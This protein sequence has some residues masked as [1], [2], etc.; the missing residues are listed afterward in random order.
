MPPEALEEEAKRSLEEQKQKEKERIEVWHM[1]HDSR[2][3]AR[4][5][6]WQPTRFDLKRWWFLRHQKTD[7]IV[8]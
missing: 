8:I 6:P 1:V 2:G 4:P 7:Q 3:V 5:W